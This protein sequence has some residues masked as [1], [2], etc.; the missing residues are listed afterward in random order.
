LQLNRVAGDRDEVADHVGIVPALALALELVL[1]S[2]DRVRAAY[3]CAGEGLRERDVVGRVGLQLD[4][5]LRLTGCR[6]CA[7]CE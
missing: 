2:G 1:L 5:G 4:H 6:G 3:L 7:A